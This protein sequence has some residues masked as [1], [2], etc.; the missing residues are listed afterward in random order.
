[1]PAMPAMSTVTEDV[2]Q[3]TCEKQNVREIPVDVR[4]VFR[5]EE[6]ANDGEEAE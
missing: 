4:P 5:E 1:M 2:E 3:R 6:E